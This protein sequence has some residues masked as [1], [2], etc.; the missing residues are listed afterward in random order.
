[1]EA[2]V[3]IEAGCRAIFEEGKKREG[4]VGEIEM[5]TAETGSVEKYIYFLF[6]SI[7]CKNGVVCLACVKSRKLYV[8]FLINMCA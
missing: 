5:E 3:G 1:M 8:V 7:D 4:M 2:E 6:V